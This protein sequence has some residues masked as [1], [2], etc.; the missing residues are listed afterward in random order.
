MSQKVVSRYSLP[1]SARAGQRLVSRYSDPLEVALTTGTKYFRVFRGYEG[2]QIVINWGVEVAG[3]DEVRLLRK[4][5]NW[6]ASTDD[7]VLLATDTFPW[8]MSTYSDHIDIDIYRVYYYTLFMH[9]A[10]GVWLWDKKMRGKTF[11]LPTGYGEDRLW[12]SLPDFY[13]TVDGER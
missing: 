11:A 4:L 12:R 5:D 3:I 1:V 8:T 6:P 2:K 10:D 9:R 7:G 13:H